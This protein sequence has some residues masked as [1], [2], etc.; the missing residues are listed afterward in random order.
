MSYRDEGVTGA[1]VRVGG[2][3]L[4]KSGRLGGQDPGPMEIVAS[5]VQAGDGKTYRAVRPIQ[6]VQMESGRELH[7]TVR[8]E[9]AP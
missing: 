2:G 3:T 6:H 7:V 9:V 4:R 5:G 8:Y 1:P